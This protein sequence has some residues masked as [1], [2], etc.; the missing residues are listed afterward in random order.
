MFVNGDV[1]AASGLALRTADG[2]LIPVQIDGKASSDGSLRFGILSA[3]LPQGAGGS[4]ELIPQAQAAPAPRAIAELFRGGFDAVVK[5]KT[6]DGRAYT[7]SARKLLQRKVTRWLDGP[8]ATEWETIGSVSD[9]NGD[10][11]HLAVRFGVRTYAGI[12]GE[13]V[14][15]VVENNWAFQPSPRNYTYDVDITIRGASVYSKQALVHYRQSRWRKVFTPFADV[16]PRYDVAYLKK[17]GA[18]PNYDPTVTISENALA[19]WKER[20]QLPEPMTTMLIQ[21]QMP[22]TG[23]RPDVGILPAWGA[24]YVISMDPRA[25]QAVLAVGTLAGSFPIHYR[26]KS[27]DRPVSL[28]TYP[29]LT[30][31]GNRGDTKHPFPACSGD[32]AIPA[33]NPDTAHQPSMA[34][35]PYLITGDHYYLEELQFWADYNIF[36]AN[37][38]YRLGARGVIAHDQVRGKAWTLRTLGHVSLITPDNDSF[39]AYFSQILE[40]NLE[41][42]RDHLAGGE[43]RNE[44]GIVNYGLEYLGGKGYAPWQDDFFTSAVNEVLAMGFDKAKPLLAFKARAPVGR[45]L[46]MCWITAAS[47]AL[48]V[49]AD[50][51][52]SLFQNYADVA[53]ATF[54]SW[55]NKDGARFLDMPCASQQMADFL[56]QHDKESGTATRYKAGQ[57]TGYASEPDGFPANMQPALAAS[58][59]ANVERAS[60]AWNL[61]A[62]RSVKPNYATQPQFAIVPRGARIVDSSAR[63]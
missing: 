59:D 28:E 29:D 51:K 12:P 6:P 17:T 49:R 55:Q 45:M 19:S 26:D 21:P 48:A 58:V 38:A 24:G 2:Q 23:G 32:C 15:I 37:P 18:V 41:W 47:Y 57:M 1:R 5:I 39:K 43:G 14:D 27:T 46:D 10:H 63:K 8:I 56:T 34:Y 40:N 44:L 7:A 60:D 11:P 3:I 22:T 52:N 53:R 35:L 25:R 31:L 54:G 50:P 33:L 20:S 36:S 16:A 62:N 4:L 9:A 61:F 30:I 42:F 13:R